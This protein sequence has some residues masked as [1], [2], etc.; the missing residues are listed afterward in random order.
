ML[1]LNSVPQAPGLRSAL[2]VA[3]GVALSWGHLAQAADEVLQ[4]VVVTAS[5]MPQLLLSMPVGATVIT[6]EQIERSGVSDANEAI[7]KLGGIVGRS[8]LFGGREYAL[9]LRGYGDAA[10]SNTVVLVDGM[11]VS[12]NEQLTARLSGIPLDQVERIEVV[13]GGNAVLWGEGATA[14][15]INVILKQNARARSHSR[16]TASVASFGGQDLQ[17]STTQNMGAVVLDASVQRVRTDGYRAHSTFKQDTANVGLQF[18]QGGFT[19][20]FRFQQEGQSAQWPGDLTFAQYAQDP[21]MA[22][23]SSLSSHGR[24]DEGRLSSSTE[25]KQGELTWQLDVASRGR[26]YLSNSFARDVSALQ[27]TPKV[28]HQGQLGDVGLAGVMGLDL[29]SWRLRT[30]DAYGADLAN[31]R[32]AAVFAQGQ[33]DWPTQTKVVL[34]LRRERIHKDDTPTYGSAYV[35]RR[36]LTATELGVNQAVSPHASVYGRLARSYRLGNVDDNSYTPPGEGPLRPQISRDKE[37]GVRWDDAVF[38]A[39]ARLFRQDNVD[40]IMYAPSPIDGLS[41]NLNA[42]PT[43]KQGI[44]LEGQWRVSDAWEVR[45]TWQR[46]DAFYRAGANAGKQQVLVAPLS[47]TVRASYRFHVHHLLEAGVQHLGAMRFGDDQ[48]NLCSTRIPT[49]SL[50]DARYAWSD[51]DWTVSLAATNLGNQVGYNYGYRCA[52]GALYPEPG[53]AFK[54]TLTRRF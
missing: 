48:A 37:V 34:G 17:A 18:G 5:R 32:N 54:A 46:L 25:L 29:Q 47:S 12:E 31:Q 7:R 3:C 6:A 41:Y 26:S 27:A 8:D 22:K 15:V 42:D 20:R 49:S 35:Q 4:P 11:R 39:T 14:G 2:A 9:D 23:P 43:R 28:S 13:R 40:E 16:V 52:T 44:E 24:N 50:F 19:Q 33:V 53:R 36:T 38:K 51:R 21:R 1:F 10:S 45:A 30:P